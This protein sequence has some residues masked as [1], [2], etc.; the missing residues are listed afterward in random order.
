MK[1]DDPVADMGD[2]TFWQEHYSL[3]GRKEGIQSHL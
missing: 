1:L 3:L 2:A